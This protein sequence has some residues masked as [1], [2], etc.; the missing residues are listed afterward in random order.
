MTIR[1]ALVGY[2]LGGRVFHAPFLAADPDLSL[3]VVVTGDPARS[4]QVRAA[5][6]DARVVPDLG[7]LLADAAADLDLVVVST[8]PARHAEQVRA[9]LAAGLHVVVDKP[10]TVHA[11]QAR[12]LV[13]LAREQGLML[14]VFHNRRWDGDFRTL[15]RLVEEG[16]LGTVRRLESR[17]ETWKPTETKPWKQQGVDT[18]VGVLYD[19][20]VH[21]LDQA[22]QLLG[23]VE[24]AYAELR[25]H[26]AGDG[27]DDDAFVALRHA[28]GAVSHLWMNTLTPLPGPRFRVV[29]SE[30]G[31]LSWG[32]DPQEAALRD[33][34]RPTDPGFGEREDGAAVLG[35]PGRQDGLPLEA[36]RYAD[37][38]RGVV[39][40][41]RDGAPAPVDPADGVAVIELV[42]Q[43]HRDFPL[44][45]GSA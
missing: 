1:T 45:Q 19:L 9:A 2:G 24:D 44:L 3:D 41:L 27:P 8:P 6:S 32:L 29:G 10:M 12:E 18:G 14:T 17:F 38:Y 39:A 11:A 40:C 35:A 25:R 23:P 13:A 36:G 31:F 28:G 34:A 26:R 22:V 16:A 7:S 20:G 37:F 5:H 21:L 33:G 15:C 43:L 4:A 42:E 30:A